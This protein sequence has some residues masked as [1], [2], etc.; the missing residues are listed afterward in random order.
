[1]AGATISPFV[2]GM[3]L[4]RVPIQNSTFWCYTLLGIF[5]LVASVPTFL[6]RSPPPLPK[7]YHEQK[8]A[9]EMEEK[10]LKDGE[11]YEKL[12]QEEG[13]D[14]NETPGEETPQ[15]PKTNL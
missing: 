14:L 2:V 7:D 8:E 5:S 6:L 11:Q 3:V 10:K 12:L 13:Q 4:S 9:E 1:M 15:P